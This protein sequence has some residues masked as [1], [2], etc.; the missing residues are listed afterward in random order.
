[1]A[2]TISTSSYERRVRISTRTNDV[3]S[4]EE[5]HARFTG[6]TVTLTRVSTARKPKSF[7]L[8]EVE[9][10]QAFTA[11]IAYK[12]WLLW[13]QDELDA[14]KILVYQDK[15][16]PGD[17]NFR[18]EYHED[19]QESYE[20]YRV[21]GWPKNGDPYLQHETIWE[22]VALEDLVEQIKDAQARVKE[23]TVQGE[24]EGLDMKEGRD[25]TEHLYLSE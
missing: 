22:H 21:E 10:D 13:H 7:R 3:G 9:L 25:F 5:L 11:L 23:G 8:D 19:G 12:K 15:L 1:M 6:K 4:V 20:I 2:E 14:A 24:T 16:E 18:E 17:I